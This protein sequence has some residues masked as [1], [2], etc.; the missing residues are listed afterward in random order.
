MAI[1][2]VN[3][4]GSDTSPYDTWAKAANLLEDALADAACVADSTIYMQSDHSEAARGQDVVL[5]N[6]TGAVATPIKV[7]SVTNTNEPPES[8][9]YENMVDGGGSIDTTDGAYDLTVTGFIVF[10]GIYLKI[11]DDFNLANT[12]KMTFFHDSKIQVADN[13]T[14]GIAGD[15]GTEWYD[16]DYVQETG[17]VFSIGG[18]WVWRG[19]SF[20]F[21]GGGSVSTSWI[22]PSTNRGGNVWI[23]DV[24]IQD[25]DAGDYLVKDTKASHVINIIRC[26]IPAAVN[27]MNA[28][29]EVPCI[30]NFHSVD[31]GD[32]IFTFK[33]YRSQ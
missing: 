3:D 12:E 11:G 4:G 27:Y 18:N 6:A 22:Q 14:I 26:K 10:V 30:V 17:G 16:V 24:D 31:D 29:P 28:G 13:I 21:G 20:S 7:I 33:E 32:N 1:L 25:M 9:D 15:G 2:Y 8:G 19:G 23:E 5:V